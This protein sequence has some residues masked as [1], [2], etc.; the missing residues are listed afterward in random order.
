MSATG[1]R[2]PAPPGRRPRGELDRAREHPPL[3]QPAVAGQVPDERHAAEP[4]EQ[5]RHRGA[6]L[7]QPGAQPPD[8]GAQ[9]L[10]QADG[11]PGG[12]RERG[13]QQV[14]RRH[15]ERPDQAD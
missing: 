1:A 6:A 11:R 2:H 15:P 12:Q 4:G 8:V 14:P 3:P 5:H 13:E 10:V 7:G 9:Q